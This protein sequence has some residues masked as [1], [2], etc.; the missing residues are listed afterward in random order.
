MAA[1]FLK[2]RGFCSSFV[3]TTCHISFFALVEEAEFLR[4]R[5]LLQ[6]KKQTESQ[7]LSPT[8]LLSHVIHGN[9]PIC[10][11]LS[12][13]PSVCICQSETTVHKLVP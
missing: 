5:K 13:T 10:Q 2:R 12:K 3:E 1:V 4:E 9:S 6:A 11:L 8:E 7:L